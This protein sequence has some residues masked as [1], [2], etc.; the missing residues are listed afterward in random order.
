MRAA[1]RQLQ[2]QLAI[3][4]D[5]REQFALDYARTVLHTGHGR[6]LADVMAHIDRLTA[7]DLQHAACQLFNAEQMTTLVYK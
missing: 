3:G 4:S 5:N 6:T 7:E 2:G 1:K